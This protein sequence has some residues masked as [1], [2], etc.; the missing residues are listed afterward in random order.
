[1]G[2]EARRGLC[3]EAWSGGSCHRR[4]DRA[5]AELFTAT[6]ARTVYAPEERCCNKP[7]DAQ[8]FLEGGMIGLRSGGRGNEMKQIAAGKNQADATDRGEGQALKAG[9]ITLTIERE[10]DE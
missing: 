2:N 7:C 4:G 10:E 1:M 8:P 3:D 9:T 6:H 5:E